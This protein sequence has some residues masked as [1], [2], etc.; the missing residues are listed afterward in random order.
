M[1]GKT[2]KCSLTISVLIS[3]HVERV[4]PS[5]VISTSSA[6]FFSLSAVAHHR[7]KSERAMG[8][9]G[10][11]ETE[12]PGAPGKLEEEDGGERKRRAHEGYKYIII[13]YTARIFVKYAKRFFF[14]LVNLSLSLSRSRTHA[15][16]LFLS[17]SL[18][19][20]VGIIDLYFF[21]FP[22]SSFCYRFIY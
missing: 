16:S 1:G 7:Q 4:R 15:L 8:M 10:E 3:V 6:S 13:S 20:R 17:I 12:R 9:A 21:F 11:G 22:F 14:F 2:V 5:L 18:V 19:R